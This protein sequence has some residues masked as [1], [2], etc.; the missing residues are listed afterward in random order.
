MRGGDCGV[1]G[2]E[3]AGGAD[4]EGDGALGE[5]LVVRAAVDEHRQEG[6]DAMGAA[7]I[8]SGMLGG[9][10]G[11]SARGRGAGIARACE[12]RRE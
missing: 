11:G 5:R 2:E 9:G 12:A 7:A 6:G 3:A 10:V 4:V 1:E 8:R